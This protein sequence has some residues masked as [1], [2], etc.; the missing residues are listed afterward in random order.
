MLG[1]FLPGDNLHAPN[2]SFSL[3]MARRGALYY[4]R[5]LEERSC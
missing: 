3:E 5:F 4:E 2:E 1:L